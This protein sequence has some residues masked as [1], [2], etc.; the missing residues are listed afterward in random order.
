MFFLSVIFCQKYNNLLHLIF[1]PTQTAS[2][3]ASLTYFCFIFLLLF[4]F[5]VL[6]AGSV[7]FIT[8]GV[9]QACSFSLLSLLS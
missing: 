6:T 7:V 5:L 4:S 8:L 2:T 1:F 3:N 9:L